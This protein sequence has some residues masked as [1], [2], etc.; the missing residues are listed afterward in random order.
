[1]S[2]LWFLFL[3]QPGGRIR[4]NQSKSDQIKPAASRREALWAWFFDI[5][6]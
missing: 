1:L 5:L 6:K 2:N 3:T 4:V